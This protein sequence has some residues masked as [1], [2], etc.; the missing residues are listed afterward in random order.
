MYRAIVGL[1]LVMGT[2]LL[3]FCFINS[4]NLF[5]TDVGHVALIWGATNGLLG[6]T[7]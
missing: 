3:L 7:L 6:Y 2:L 4:I 1:S 5:T